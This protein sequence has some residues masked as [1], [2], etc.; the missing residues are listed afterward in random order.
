LFIEAFLKF[1]VVVGSFAPRQLKLGQ[2]K[3]HNLKVE[4]TMKKIILVLM[5]VFACFSIGSAQSGKPATAK[6]KKDLFQLIS[7]NDEGVVQGIKDGGL[8]A[9]NLA[10]ELSV[11]KIDLN[12]DGQPEYLAGLEDSYFCGAHGNCPTWVY[13]KTGG[14]Y[15]LLLVVNGETLALDKT[16][17]NKF[18]DLRSEGSN[19]AFESSGTVFKFDGNTYKESECYTVT[20]NEKNK[21]G[22]K[23][24]V[25]CG[26]GN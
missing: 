4:K 24:V 23:A 22:K 7:K 16:S 12:K 11:K 17:T 26:D 14:E 13:R 18:R 19:S 15:R 20:Y 9:A 25:K 2:L 5:V 3:L 8:V 1:H 6:E 21:K 10:K